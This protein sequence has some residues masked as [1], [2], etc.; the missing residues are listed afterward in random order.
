MFKVEPES[1]SDING[2][3]HIY[4]HLKVVCDSKSTQ[5][6]DYKCEN[7]I[8]PSSKKHFVT[9]TGSDQWFEMEFPNFPIY[10]EHYSIQTADLKSSSLWACPKAWELFG[11]TFKR[12]VISIDN[13]TNSELTEA[14]KI[15]TYKIY[16]PDYYIGLKL[17][18]RDKNHAGST[19][20]RFYKI[21][22]FGFSR[23]HFINKNTCLKNQTIIIYYFVIALLL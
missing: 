3:I 18:M 6:P 12:E 2:F 5:S 8:N 21:D 17:V 1:E 14:F 19:D 16:K 22:V 9:N 10:M 11:I 7:A 13:Q 4:P 20:L 15:I 23:Y